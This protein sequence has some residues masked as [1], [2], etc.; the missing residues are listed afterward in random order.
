MKKGLI[1]AARYLTLT[2][3]LL[4]GVWYVSVN[5]EKFATGARFTAGNISLLAGLCMLTLLFESVRMK[6]QVRKLGH[7]ISLLDAWHIFTVLQATNHIVLKAGTFS[8]GY[9]M[10][11]KYRISFHAYCAF[12]ITY[13]VI[14]V[15]AS[16]VFGLCVSIVYILLGTGTSLL[17]P[18]FFV[19]IIVTCAAVISLA[20]VNIPVRRLPHFMQRV[21][22]AWR[23]IYSDYNLIL[24]MVVIEMFYFL[25]C[26]LRFLVAVS[27]FSVDMSF[28][29]AVVVVTVGN[30]LRIASIV[31]GGLGIAE[32]ASGWTAAVVGNDAGIAGLSAGLDRLIYVV[33]L[34][35][36]GGVGFLTLS[37]RS[38]FHKPKEEEEMDEFAAG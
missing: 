2:T 24:T 35:V 18:L 29:D 30:F 31:P 23:E 11:K 19:A 3:I 38:E 13:V 6:F 32:V 16:G 26:S 7:R 8:A 37:G 25:T 21:I 20:T 34:M 17:L 12:V 4:F 10:S 36:F 22:K 15:L 33:L 1:I 9:Y 27:M 28:L 5:Y 14:M